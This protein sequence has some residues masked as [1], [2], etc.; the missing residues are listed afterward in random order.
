MERE[1]VS[2]RIE[3]APSDS[4]LDAPPDRRRADAEREL[5]GSVGRARRRRAAVPEGRPGDLSGL[6]PR[7][8]RSR[9]V[10]FAER[11]RAAATEAAR[12]P[13]Y[14]AA[15]PEVVFGA[16]RELR[17]SGRWRD[18]RTLARDLGREG[19]GGGAA[20]G[21]GGELSMGIS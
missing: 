20:G 21:R 15:D 9:A 17:A 14:A 5:T 1:S 7:E 6:V 2:P 11:A 16:V 19:G 4:A 3:P 13:A 18:P 10:A 12:V 8:D